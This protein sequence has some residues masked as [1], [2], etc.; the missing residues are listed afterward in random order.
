MILVSS[1]VRMTTSLTVLLLLLPLSA[2]ATDYYLGKQASAQPGIAIPDIVA[3][4]ARELHPGDR[5]FFQGGQ[6]FSGNLYFGPDDAGTAT[7]PIVISS[8]GSGRATVFAGDGAAITLYNTA[9][10]SI[11]RLNLIGSGPATSQGNGIDAGVYLPGS[12]KLPYLRCDDLSISG[13][14]NGIQIWAWYSTATRAWPGFTDVRLTN[15]EVFNNRSEGIKTSGT[16]RADGNGQNF[17]HTNVTIAHCAVWDNR[18]DPASTS[19][20]GSGII[21]SGVDGGTVEYCVAHDNGGRG[22]A[23]GGGPFGIWTW[24]SRGVTLQYNLVYNQHTSSSL[25]GGAFDLDGGSANCVVQYNYSYNNDGPAIGI[26]Q[27]QDASP[28]VN[29]VVRFNISEN[30]CRKTTQGVVYVGEFS[31]PYGI[32]SAEIYQN[33]FFVSANASGGKP[34]VVAVQNH[35]DI[36]N[37]NL[38]NNVFIATHSGS[39][40]TGVTAN[41][42][43]ARFQGNNYWG[44]SFDLAAFRAGGQE[45]LDNLPVGS[46]VDPQLTDAGNG[47]SVTDPTLLPTITAY[48]L[49]NQSPLAGTGL[50]LA[51]S[52]GLDR[53]TTDFRGLTLDPETFD[54]GASA[55]R[56]EE[57]PPPPSEPAPTVLLDDH[58]DGS[59]SLSS[60]VPD[61][62]NVPVQ[63]WVILSGTASIADGAASTNSTL[64]AVL[65]TGAA[66]A[67]VETSLYLGA[68]DSGLLLRCS[69]SSN[70]LR[71]SLSSTAIRLYKTQGGSTSLIGAVPANLALGQIYNVRAILSGSTVSLF[72]Q[73]VN[74]ATFSTSFNQTATRHGL[75]ANN[76]GA[77]RWERFTV[78]LP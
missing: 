5:V 55:A 76:S 7:D 27:F 73:G 42:A 53:G 35:D 74:V 66:D 37:V 49:A 28:L 3:L 48:T 56:F 17:S 30:D 75:Y 20:T 10:F 60:R 16:W 57:G 33:T 44:G 36:A 6:T 64:R 78:S 67:S 31:E 63:K 41:P 62:V 15:L 22:P 19:H 59:G 38:R 14:K 18:G 45:T 46:R 25:D 4:N 11:S 23:T 40:I 34:P 1:A 43:K 47:G 50:N 8:F 70:Y 2:F 77:R 54:V 24:E 32:N 26:I 9:G 12:T 61:T 21:L 71:I 72:V 58:F 39:L 65:E 68:N 51:R 52:F 29:S 69:N 13:F